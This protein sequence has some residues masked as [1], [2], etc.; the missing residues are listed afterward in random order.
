[1]SETEAERS[2][3]PAEWFALDKYHAQTFVL[4]G[5]ANHLQE[6]LLASLSALAWSGP[7]HV[8]CEEG[9]LATV[10]GL[11]FH[12]QTLENFDPMG[13]SNLP[14]NARRLSVSLSRSR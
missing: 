14:A 1:M 4:A 13:L 2:P 7:V 11:G 12:A 9:E 6:T 3:L 10:A 8:T 5:P